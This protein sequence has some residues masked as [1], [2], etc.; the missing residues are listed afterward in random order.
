MGYHFKWQFCCLPLS[1]DYVQGPTARSEFPY[2]GRARFCRE[3][4]AH[5]RGVSLEGDGALEAE[6]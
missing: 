2:D 3:R 1:L 4:L 6:R 5:F